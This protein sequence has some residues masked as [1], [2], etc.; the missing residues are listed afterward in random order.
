MPRH[1]WSV[2]CREPIVDRFSNNVSLI[3]LLE[4]MQFDFVRS[5]GVNAK[6]PIIPI[7]D[8]CIVSYWVLD[9]KEP[10]GEER[11]RARIKSPNGKI[12]ATVEQNYSMVG[13]L[14]ARNILFARAVPMPQSGR[15]LV[16][17]Q[18]P[19]GKSGWRSV[20]RLPLDVTITV[21]Q[22]DARSKDS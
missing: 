6:E 5:A 9:A 20:A 14:R 22:V 18:E 13:Y 10:G 2:L 3:G 21:K 19:S 1:V 7:A 11:L 8:L 16:E 17:V 12:L 15:Y 4:E